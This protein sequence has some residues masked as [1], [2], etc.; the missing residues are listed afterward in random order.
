MK[1]I[2]NS[3]PQTKLTGSYKKKECKKETFFI[4][5][6]EECSFPGKSFSELPLLAASVVIVYLHFYEIKECS[7]IFSVHFQQT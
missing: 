4:G 5:T 2:K 3:Q 7:K 1:K 6:F